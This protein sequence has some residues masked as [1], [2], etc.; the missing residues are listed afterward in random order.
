MDLQEISIHRIFLY[1]VYV[2]GLPMHEATGSPPA[3]R[4]ARKRRQLTD[5]VAALAFGL[6][7]EFGYD[8]P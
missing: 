2:F 7:E 6:F 8:A 1:D 5:R 3:N 4:R